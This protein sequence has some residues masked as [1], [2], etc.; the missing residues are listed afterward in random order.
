MSIYNIY[1]I[2]TEK[3]NETQYDLDIQPPNEIINKSNNNDSK[4]P[5]NELGVNNI[6]NDEE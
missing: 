1:L 3:I 4:M 6:N 2:R 5:I